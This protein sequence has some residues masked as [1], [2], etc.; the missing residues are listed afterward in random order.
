MAKEPKISLKSKAQKK[1][2]QSVMSKATKKSDEIK[3]HKRRVGREIAETKRE[4]VAIQAGGVTS[5]KDKRRISALHVKMANLQATEKH[6]ETPRVKV[7][8]SEAE[9]DIKASRKAISQ[10]RKGESLTWGQI[11][12]RDLDGDGTDDYA[13]DKIR[14]PRGSSRRSGSNSGKNGGGTGGVNIKM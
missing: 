12:K 11:K 1:S 5:G 4:I 7:M 3:E 10:L 2:L 14:V 6:L 8:E 13:G 9:K